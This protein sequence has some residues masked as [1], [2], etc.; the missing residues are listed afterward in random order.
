MNIIR[1]IM[2]WWNRNTTLMAAVNRKDL[3]VIQLLLSAGAD[4]NI[5][6]SDGIA[7][8]VIATWKRSPKM[9]LSLLSAGANP[10][11]QDSDG[12]TAL[13]SASR[14]GHI[15]CM[16]ILLTAGADPSLTTADGL[17]AET[18]AYGEG[19]LLL[20]EFTAPIPHA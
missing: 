1:S 13:M 4:P 20:K 2:L 3:D 8:L 18:L 11:M 5:Q 15:E 6:D 9:V 17:T 14:I 12:W 19:L 10:N 16:S 7:P